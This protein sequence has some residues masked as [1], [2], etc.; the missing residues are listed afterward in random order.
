[1]KPPS[2]SP[3]KPLPWPPLTGTGHMPLWMRLRDGMLTVL[4]WVVLG[5]LLLDYFTYP[6][7]EQPSKQIPSLE[8]FIKTLSP[9]LWLSAVLMGWLTYWAIK[10]SKFLHW[11]SPQSPPPVLSI[12]EQAAFF[13]LSSQAVEDSQQTGLQVVHF[14]TKNQLLR[15]SAHELKS[16]ASNLTSA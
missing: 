11:G 10:R 2:L 9:F 4:A 1:M 12:K 5:I 16:F 13:G 6:F 14:D 8:V 15:I 3:K 7:L